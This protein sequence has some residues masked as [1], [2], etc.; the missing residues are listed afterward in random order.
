VIRLVE[1]VIP[2]D[3]TTVATVDGRWQR[4]VH[5]SQEELGDDAM[6]LR[7][8]LID[9]DLASGDTCHQMRWADQD[10]ERITTSVQLVLTEERIL[11]DFAEYARDQKSTS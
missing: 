10:S 11:A 1:Y 7:V 9:V 4:T 3:V 8:R 6:E 2:P 5:V